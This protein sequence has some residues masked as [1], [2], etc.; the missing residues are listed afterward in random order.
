[1]AVPYLVGTLVSY[2]QMPAAPPPQTVTTEDASRHRQVSPGG[3]GD[4]TTSVRP[5]A[6]TLS[7]SVGW[8]C[9]RVFLRHSFI[10]GI[11]SSTTG[12]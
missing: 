4:R 5:T 9:F 1:M 7:A 11:L 2:R 6:L 3:G 10:Y 8:L 12:D